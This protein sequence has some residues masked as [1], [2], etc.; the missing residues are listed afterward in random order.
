MQSGIKQLRAA[1]GNSATLRRPMT[2][3]WRLQ[4]SCIS[5]GCMRCTFFFI[6]NELTHST[7]QHSAS[8]STY[9]SYHRA[10]CI[11]DIVC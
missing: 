6:V 9:A 1:G 4:S 11:A 3:W 8:H 7:A 10:T 2:T 5:R